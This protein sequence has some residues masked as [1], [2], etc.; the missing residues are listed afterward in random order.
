MGMGSSTVMTELASLHARTCLDFC[1]CSSFNLSP[2][3][4]PV[5]LVGPSLRCTQNLVIMAD[6]SPKALH[7]HNAWIT[8]WLHW[9]HLLV[10]GLFEAGF[11]AALLCVLSLV[12][13]STSLWKEGDCYKAASVHN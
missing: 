5:H 10:L 6:I 4:V 1:W 11:L 3:H 7:S 12:P 13:A 2:N 8:L 9:F